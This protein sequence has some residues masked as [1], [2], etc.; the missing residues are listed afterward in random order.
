MSSQALGS[1]VQVAKENMLSGQFDLHSLYFIDESVISFDSLDSNQPLINYD[2]QKDLLARIDGFAILA[3][4]WKNCASCSKVGHE[5]TAQDLLPPTIQTNIRL[6]FNQNAANRRY[7]SK[8]WSIPDQ[9]GVWSDG[10]SATLLLPLKNTKVSQLLFE[11]HPFI[12]PTHPA[13]KVEVII[14]GQNITTV[15][16]TANS[17]DS[18]AIPIPEKIQQQLLNGQP[19]M[20]V[21][22]F[23]PNTARPIDFAVNNDTRDLG[24]HLL[25]LT[26]VSK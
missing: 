14:N 1:S 9:E 11:T 8:G 20:K 16:L 2:P 10:K 25:A 12:T 3:P 23:F 15:T 6:L 24:L 26:V 19:L 7:L 4:G 5:I 22:L 21:Q 13:Q 18:F 17:G